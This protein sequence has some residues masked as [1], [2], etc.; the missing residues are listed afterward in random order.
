[1]LR[2]SKP[3]T[4]TLNL[5]AFHHPP[6]DLHRMDAPISKQEVWNTIKSLPPDKVPGPDGFTGRFFKECWNTIKLDVMAVIGAVH[7]GDARQL[8]LLNSAYIVLIPKKEEAIRVGDFRPISL[9]HSFAK[10]LTTILANR[11][12]QS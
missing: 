2:N 12:P 7:A 1:M 10:Q 9:V 6:I 3:R 5:E 11:L 4:S 8:R